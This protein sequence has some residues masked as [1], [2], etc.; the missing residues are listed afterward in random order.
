MGQIDA[1]PGRYCCCSFRSVYADGLYERRNLEIYRQFSITLIPP[2]C[3]EN[4]WG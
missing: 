1:A 4:L 3:F 2:C